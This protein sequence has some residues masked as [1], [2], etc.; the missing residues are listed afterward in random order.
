MEE[1]PQGT[2]QD[3]LDWCIRQLETGLLRRNP[4]PQ[5]A[6]DTKKILRVLRS[7][8][9]TF[10]KK[11]QVMSRVFGN[12]QLK[13]AED[14]QQKEKSA[15][16]P[17]QTEEL[18][19]PDSQSVAFRKFPKD[20]QSSSTHWVF[21]PS[22]NSFVFNFCVEQ[23]DDVE[24]A[25]PECTEKSPATCGQLEGSVLATQEGSDFAF[26]FPISVE[27]ASSSQ[28]C[29]GQGGTADTSGDQ[30]GAKPSL[31]AVR[32]VEEAQEAS[33]QNVCNVELSC[34][35]L[36]LSANQNLTLEATVQ[37]IPDAKNKKKKKNKTQTKS[38]CA[39]AEKKTQKPRAEPEK[40]PPAREEDSQALLKA[41]ELQKELD[42][43]VEQLEKGLQQ[44]KTTPRQV[45]EALRGIKTLRSEKLALGK[46]RQV[47]RILFGDYRRKMEDERQK[48]IKL[49]QEAAKSARVIE[50]SGAA[51]QKTSK[52]FRKCVQQSQSDNGQ[53]LPA[54][55]TDSP[56]QAAPS[57]GRFIFQTS[58]EPFCFNFF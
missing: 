31:S 39:Q 22:D 43:C 53:E 17:V 29:E 41:I 28:N 54:D 23:T 52:V 30:P 8:K 58:R 7:Q 12:Y 55:S 57:K 44:Q 1:A 24:E 45:E 25:E 40:S 18:T 32:N 36:G 51:R 21:T 14:R 34:S 3:E 47:M 49:M 6:K 42:W 27:S 48:Q 15:S 56:A 38:Q 19:H 33:S 46:K 2:F 11:R 9:A 5:E 50:V 37:N 16:P 26:N 35:T 13:M 10:V 4:T 20:D